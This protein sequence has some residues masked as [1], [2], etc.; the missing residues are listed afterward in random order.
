MSK[1]VVSAMHH[2]SSVRPIF[3]SLLFPAILQLRPLNCMFD[4]LAEAAV[5]HASNMYICKTDH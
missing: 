3:P 5:R 1:Q 4:D 2:R